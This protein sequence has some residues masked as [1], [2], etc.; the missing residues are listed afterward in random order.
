MN[1]R[2]ILGGTSPP[3]PAAD[4]AYHLGARAE[5]GAL[6]PLSPLLVRPHRL[7]GTASIR[8]CRTPPHGHLRCP[9]FGHG[10]PVG[11]SFP[12]SHHRYC[13]RQ[14]LFARLFTARLRAAN[15][16]I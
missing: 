3:T 10:L 4:V 15:P 11:A 6:L 8:I 12:G 7:L 14:P 13:R 16:L 2:S 9:Q 5:H 1:W